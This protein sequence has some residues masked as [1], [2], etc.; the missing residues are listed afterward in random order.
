MNPGQGCGRVTVIP[1]TCHCR[2]ALK[3]MRLSRVKR[4]DRD[5]QAARPGPPVLAGSSGGTSAD[6]QVDTKQL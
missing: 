3:H 4:P 1:S 5:E 6:G 2:R